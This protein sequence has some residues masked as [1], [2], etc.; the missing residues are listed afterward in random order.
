VTRRRSRTENEIPLWLLPQALVRT[1]REWGDALYRISVKRTHWH[2]F[3]VTVRTRPIPKEL[4]PVNVE[5]ISTNSPEGMGKR[6]RGG[7]RKCPA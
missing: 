5:T 1:I 7:R 6:S 4:A 3:N 2:H